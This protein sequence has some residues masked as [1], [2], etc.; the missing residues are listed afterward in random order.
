MRNGRQTCFWIDAWLV[1]R[2]LCELACLEIPSTDLFRPVASYWVSREG[3]KWSELNGF[4]PNDIYFRLT[5]S[6]LRE[7]N[8]C[9]DKIAW[10]YTS[11]G[12]FSVSSTYE[13]L[14]EVHMPNENNLWKR[15]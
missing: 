12:S 4:L 7:D 11:N 14:C 10:R 1:D 2:P 3:W 15:I 9:P 8:R 5:T 13:K 6:I